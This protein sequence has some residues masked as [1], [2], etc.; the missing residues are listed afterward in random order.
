MSTLRY[1]H[2]LNSLDLYDEPY[3]EFGYFNEDEVVKITP[4]KLVKHLNSKK[5]NESNYSDRVIVLC[6]NIRV[7]CDLKRELKSLGL[8]VPDYKVIFETTLI[9][10]SSSRHLGVN[11]A[12]VPAIV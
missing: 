4:K 7:C 6:P 11:P 5:F 12:S 9:T 8:K 1:N 10:E 2:L 3:L